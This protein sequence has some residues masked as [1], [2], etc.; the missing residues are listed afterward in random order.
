LNDIS[1]VA[2][3]RLTL[4]RSSDDNALTTLAPTPCRPPASLVIALLELAT[5]VEHREN[6]FERTLL[7]LRVLVHRNA[8][9][10]VAHRYRGAVLVQRQRD[11]R[12]VAVHRFVY[13]VVEDFPHQVMQAGGAHTSDVHSG[14]LADRF[15]SFENGDVFCGVIRG[16]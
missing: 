7:R 3:S 15:Q 4:A 16:H 5:R 9:A 11:V 14:T 10:V 2:P 1:Q 6:D 12:G 13:G 8:A